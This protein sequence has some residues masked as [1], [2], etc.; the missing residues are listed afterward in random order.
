MQVQHLLGPLSSPRPCLAEKGWLFLPGPVCLQRGGPRVEH[1]LRNAE[2]V[3]K[4]VGM[5]GQVLGLRLTCW[6]VSVFQFRPEAWGWSAPWRRPVAMGARVGVWRG[7]A[8]WARLSERSQRKENGIQACL[9]GKVWKGERAPGGNWSWLR[10]RLPGRPGL[11]G[12]RRTG[13][14]GLGIWTFGAGKPG[15]FSSHDSRW[16]VGSALCLLGSHCSFLFGP[17]AGLW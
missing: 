12:P 3:G 2:E 6:A 5:E 1:R 13:S 15:K 17:G 14:P 4:G 8:C 10:G 7:K 11:T 16:L 9:G